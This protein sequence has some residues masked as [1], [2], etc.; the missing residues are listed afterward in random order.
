MAE[1]MGDDHDWRIFDVEKGMEVAQ[2]DNV[3]HVR[4]TADPSKVTT[5]TNEE[6]D[7]LRSG[8]PNP[9]GLS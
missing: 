8:G 2:F 9:K 1:S 4:Y 6:F 5:L 3:W 7:Q